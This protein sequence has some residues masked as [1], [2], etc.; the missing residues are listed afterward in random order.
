MQ[1]RDSGEGFMQRDPN[2][3]AAGGKQSV[4]EGSPN[5][6]LQEGCLLDAEGPAGSA[7]AGQGRAGE[8]RDDLDLKTKEAC[9]KLREEAGHS[10][11]EREGRRKSALGRGGQSQLQARLSCVIPSQQ[12]DTHLV[13]GCS[14]PSDPSV[15]SQAPGR[16]QKRPRPHR[17]HPQAR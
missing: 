6:S 16:G 4:S 7:Q 9:C 17:P 10:G 8:R 14:S 2:L 15:R 1:G 12:V 3:Q 13:R 11:A 5:L